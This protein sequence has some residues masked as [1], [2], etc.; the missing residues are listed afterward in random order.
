MHDIAPMGTNRWEPIDGRV[1]QFCTNL[2]EGRWILIF[3]IIIVTM[4]GLIG[5]ALC[6][7]AVHARQHDDIPIGYSLV[8]NYSMSLLK[9]EGSLGTKLF[10]IQ[11]GALGEGTAFFLDLHG[12]SRFDLGYQQAS[13]IGDK[14][15]GCYE[16]LFDWM[17]GTGVGSTLLKQLL[18]QF[19]F[20][21]WQ[22]A[23]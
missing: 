3:D 10:E 4:R 15:I 1:V 5:V 20:W 21:Q 8:S 9:E 16:A 11:V 12:E 22:I 23:L 19:L 7:A 14:M 6:F 2:R 18:Q 17:I 13:I